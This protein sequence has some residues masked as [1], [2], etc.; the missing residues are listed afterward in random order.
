MEFIE[1]RR[2]LHAVLEE[3]TQQYYG[4]PF[5]KYMLYEQHVLCTD[6]KSITINLPAGCEDFPFSRSRRTQRKHGTYDVYRPLRQILR[7]LKRA[8]IA[9]II[10][11]KTP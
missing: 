4:L 7:E 3:L 6:V 9:V 10:W 5:W 1:Y 2:S 8:G 11:T